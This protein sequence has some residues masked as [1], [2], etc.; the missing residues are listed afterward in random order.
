M[1]N[2]DDINLNDLEDLIK[3]KDDIIELL[4]YKNK[5]LDFFKDEVCRIELKIDRN[6]FTGEVKSRSFKI[7]SNVLEMFLEFTKKHP[8]LKQQDIVT[9]FFIDGLEKYNR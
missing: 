8:E 3:S 4:K 2:R 6:K 5:I 9:Q 7:D 1:I